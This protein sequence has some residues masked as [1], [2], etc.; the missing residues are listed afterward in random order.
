MRAPSLIDRLPGR[1]PRLPGAHLAFTL[2]ELM[3]V[4]AIIAV[5][6]AILVIPA[7]G[8]RLRGNE[9]SAI[10]A[11]RTISTQEENFRGSAIVDQDGNGVGEFGLLGEL[12]GQVVP[13]RT[14]ASVPITPRMIDASFQP[15][16]D[17][18]G[19]RYGYFFRIYLPVDD[20]GGTGSDAD[21]GGDATTPGPILADAAGIARQ[22]YY[23]CGYAWPSGR[24]TGER[25]FFIDHCGVLYQTHG[26]AVKYFG[27]TT[28]PAANAAYGAEVYTST[29]AGGAG[30]TGND[31]NVWTVVQ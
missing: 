22:Q 10:G 27:A 16:A 14:S 2:I 12:T 18:F 1:D 13:R 20:A 30:N 3:V 19:K 11:L 17:G 24:N 28:V 4:V 26:D 9:T 5:L 31:G 15:D 8:A 23:W 21:L 6:V 7:L 25:A 29:V